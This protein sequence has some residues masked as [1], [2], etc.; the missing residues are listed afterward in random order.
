MNK[1]SG[2][3]CSRPEFR[4]KNQETRIQNPFKDARNQRTT[5]TNL[6]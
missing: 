1:N 3:N 4:I 5:N 2:I 6:S